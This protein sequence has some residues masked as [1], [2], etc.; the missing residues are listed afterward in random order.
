MVEVLTQQTEELRRNGAPRQGSIVD[1]LEESLEQARADIRDL[2]RERDD[3]QAQLLAASVER[4]RSLLADEPSLA[5]E[6]MSGG[7][8]S[9]Q[10]LEALREQE[11]C[12]QKLRVYING[13]LMRVIERHPEILE[14]GQSLNFIN[15]SNYYTINTSCNVC[16]PI[17]LILPP[18]FLL[19]SLT[20]SS[21]FILANFAL[22]CDFRTIIV[23]SDHR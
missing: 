1:G 19:H 22:S 10:I 9:Q 4:G 21:P 23:S 6:L 11:V 5:D 15:R 13:I 16:I 20:A 3:L 17:K 7:G 8:D 18:L 12:N 14:I 2:Q